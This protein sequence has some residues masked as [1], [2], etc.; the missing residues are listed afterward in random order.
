[1]PFVS[2]GSGCD[3]CYYVIPVG[4]S[5][6]DKTYNVVKMDFLAAWKSMDKI[7][8][9]GLWSRGDSN[10]CIPF[11]GLGC[12]YNSDGFCIIFVGLGCC[13]CCNSIPFV[14]FSGGDKTYNVVFVGLGSV[15]SNYCMVLVGLCCCYESNY[16]KSCCELFGYCLEYTEFSSELFG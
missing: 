4:F 2:L 8:L 14:G 7:E 12:C 10:K 1:M 3:C 15:G 9:V 16:I 5:G 11:V 13:Y 6:G